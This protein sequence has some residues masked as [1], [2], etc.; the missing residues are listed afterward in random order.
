MLEATIR[1]DG[2]SVVAC[3]TRCTVAERRGSGR[4]DMARQRRKA[5]ND[6]LDRLRAVPLFSACDEQELNLLAALGTEVSVP[7]GELLMTQGDHSRDAYLVM[8]GSATCLRDGEEIAHFGPG[9][10]FGEMALITDRPRSAT[11]VADDD[12]SVRA[13]HAGE[14]RRLLNDVPGVAVKVLW[15]TAERLIEAEAAPTH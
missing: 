12:L 14:F 2:P 1:P 5:G 10:F 7:S 15:V 13:F 4:Q 11:V 6:Y 3:P 9:D 8:S